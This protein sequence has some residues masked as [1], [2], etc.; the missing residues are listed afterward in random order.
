MSTAIGRWP[1]M[2]IDCPDARSLA[3]FYSAITG[4]PLAEQMGPDWVQLDSGH[5]STIGFQQVNGY[6]GP[7]WPGQEVPQQAHL[8]FV[9]D[10]LSDAERRVVALG[11][12]RA[13]TQPGEGYLVF[14][15]PVGH[16]FCLVRD[17]SQD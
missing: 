13:A 6:R 1:I 16:P 5:T 2:V 7:Q 11:A 14:L 17:T 8:D 12:T 9:V 10:D 4:W 15:D 3:E